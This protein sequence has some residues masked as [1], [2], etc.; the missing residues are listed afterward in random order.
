MHTRRFLGLLLALL[1]LLAACSGGGSDEGAGTASPASGAD[2]PDSVAARVGDQEITTARLDDLLQAAKEGNAQVKQMLDG[3]QGDQIKTQLEARLLSQMIVNEIVIQSAKD[4]GLDVS[5]QDV[6]AKRS[7]L[8]QQAGGE[9]QFKSQID[10]AGLTDEQLA[11]E[12]T[13]IAALDKVR[14]K[15]TG[16]ASPAPAPAPSPGASPGPV[17][18]WLIEQVKQADVVVADR[19]GHWDPETAS[20]VPPTPVAPPTGATTTA[21]SDTSSPAGTEPSPAASATP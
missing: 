6:E 18:A 8:T 12:L 4:M 10:Q 15:L 2:L 19:Y 13:G 20:V 5:Q 21:P 14:E 16:S 3:D 9:E 1:L 17:E 11:Q 7:E